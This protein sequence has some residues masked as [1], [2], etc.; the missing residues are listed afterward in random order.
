MIVTA[1][2]S[3]FLQPH[4]RNPLIPR[5][6][7]ALAPRA[8]GSSYKPQSTPARIT[9]RC[10]STDGDDKDQQTSQNSFSLDF[11]PNLADASPKETAI[12]RIWA[13]VAVVLG[14]LMLL[15]AA[16]SGDWSRIGAITKEQELQLQNLVPVVVAGH[17]ACAVAA[18]TISAG[19]G[20]NWAPR[21]AK[22]MASGFVGLVEVALLPQK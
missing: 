3:N 14:I 2:V 6:A 7:F 13:P 16:Y 15:D 21:A 12:L 9:P 1:N 19:R 10:N 22:T 5:A 18:G 11:L 8:V 17:G 4:H 20:E